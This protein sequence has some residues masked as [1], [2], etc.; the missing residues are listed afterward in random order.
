MAN[1]PA[2]KHAAVHLAP[3]KRPRQVRFVDSLPR[4]SM[5]KVRRTE[6]H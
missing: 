5:G 4:N 2:T 1:H 3:Y 6:L